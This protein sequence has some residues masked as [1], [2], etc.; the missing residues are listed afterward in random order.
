MY[1]DHV[2][3]EPAEPAEPRVRKLSYQQSQYQPY[4]SSSAEVQDYS[5]H[6]DRETDKP[7]RE[8]RKI[9]RRYQLYNRCSKKE[10][11][12]VGQHVFANAKPDS[13]FGEYFYFFLFVL[14]Y[15]FIYLLFN[16]LK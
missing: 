9:V 11:Q 4:P 1:Q 12:I 16:I 13:P 8:V 6:V 10:V 3:R 7:D 5:Q 14:F 15:L 2:D